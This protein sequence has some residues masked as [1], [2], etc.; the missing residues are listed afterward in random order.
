MTKRA[1]VSMRFLFPAM[2][3]VGGC[4]LWALRRSKLTTHTRWL[5]WAVWGVCGLGAIVCL[6]S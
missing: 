5:L 2:F 1:S 3:L 6:E 4:V